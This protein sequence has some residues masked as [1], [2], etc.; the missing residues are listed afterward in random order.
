MAVLPLLKTATPRISNESMSQG[1][2][3]LGT[4]GGVGHGD[5]GFVGYMVAGTGVSFCPVL[6]DQVGLYSLI[7]HHSPSRCTKKASNTLRQ[8]ECYTHPS[9]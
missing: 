5:L 1:L 8:T 7:Y 2:Y 6:M 9:V 3:V 4:L